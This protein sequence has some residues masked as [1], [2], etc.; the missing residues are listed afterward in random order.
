MARWMSGRMARWMSGRPD[1]CT[2]GPLGRSLA[3]GGEHYSNSKRDLPVD[4]KVETY[5][6]QTSQV[7][8]PPFTKIMA[9][10]RDFDRVCRSR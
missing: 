10:A 4:P 8:S 3:R 6:C 7:D 5:P 2:Q 1:R 9:R